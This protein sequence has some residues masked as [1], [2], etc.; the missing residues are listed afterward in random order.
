MIAYFLV[1]QKRDLHG[2]TDLIIR[3]SPEYGRHP[4]FSRRAELKCVLINGYN[5]QKKIRHLLCCLEVFFY[6]EIGFAKGIK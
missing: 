1:L 5:Y 2:R 4:N 6:W 3:K